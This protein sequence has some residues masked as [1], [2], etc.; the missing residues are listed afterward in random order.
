MP[1]LEETVVT[2]AT[3]SHLSRTNT[4]AALRQHIP[5]VLTAIA[6]AF[7]AS[8]LPSSAQSKTDNAQP[9]A[10]QS[11]TEAPSFTFKVVT[12]MVIVEVVVRDSED[13]PV[14]DLTAKDL[15]VSE[16][17][18]DSKELPETIGSL[19]VISEPLAQRLDNS[20]G[21]VLG[22]LHKS[23]CALT[24]AYELS[25]YLSP[26][27]RK[28]GLHRISVT[29]S[30][31]DLTLYFRPGY[32]IEA[33]K[34]AEVQAAELADHKTD[35]ELETQQ[36]LEAEQK[37]HPELE[38][39]RIACYDS[40][41][42]TTFELSL[43]K[44]K[45][46]DGAAYEF[47][48]PSSYFASRPAAASSHPTQLDFSLCTFEYG[49]HPLLHFEGT[50][51]AGTSPEE[52]QLLGTQGFAHA[53]T[54]Q[55]QEPGVSALSARLVVRDR[56]TGALGSGEMLLLP[57]S[58]DEFPS[59][60]PEGQTTPVFGTTK[61]DTP[62]A[63]CGDV[64]QLPP[65]TTHLPRFSEF[66][67]VAPIYT[68]SLGVY[69]RFF[70]LGIPG[71]TNRTEWFGVNYWGV[72]GVDRPGKYE[73]R[74]LSDDGAKVYVDEKLI[75][76]DDA[77]HPAQRSRG[78]VLLDAGAHDIRVSYFQGPRTEVALV[79]LVKPPKGGWRLFDTRD[80]PDPQDLPAQR[81][82]LTLP[83]E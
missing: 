37:K 2:A 58:R 21:I 53:V 81:K 52:Y 4:R 35:T 29:S 49:G 28:D 11:P 63:L 20:K 75:V 73:F 10:V 22:W 5:H 61:R 8:A 34:P 54:F 68:T 64:Y 67:A 45:S 57:L 70:T 77:L 3:I 66:D 74:L 14:R 72:F 24:G 36:A 38:L 17:I 12:R 6:I 25:Y 27:S 47:V 42:T 18:G 19:H 43:R 26:E 55:P 46:K 31:K 71:V 33:D 23:F 40:L 56:D 7:L 9:I 80:F 16:T 59:P 60:I 1:S 62:L 15:R 30:R 50:V 41:N 48:V 83:E 82:K 78:K 79:L 76:S 39:A 69:S 51:Q 13:N 65:W 44:L 32:K